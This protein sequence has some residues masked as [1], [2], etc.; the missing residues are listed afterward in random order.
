MGCGISIEDKYETCA[1]LIDEYKLIVYQYA[2]GSFTDKEQ[3]VINLYKKSKETKIEKL[4]KEIDNEISSKQ[5]R[6]RY[7]ELYNSFQKFI[8][9]ISNYDESKSENF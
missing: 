1:F 3:E 9:M 4:L 5:Q 7:I 6:L 2:E 8:D